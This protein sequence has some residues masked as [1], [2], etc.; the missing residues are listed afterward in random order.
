MQFC[1]SSGSLRGSVLHLNLMKWFMFLTSLGSSDRVFF[2]VQ[3]PCVNTTE[4]IHIHPHSHRRSLKI[5]NAWQ[6]ERNLI[7]FHIFWEKKTC[8]MGNV[9]CSFKAGIHIKGGAHCKTNM[10]P[11]WLM[12]SYEGVTSHIL[13]VT[14]PSDSCVKDQSIINRFFCYKTSLVLINCSFL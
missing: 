2:L 5:Q 8:I 1:S 10:G 7:Y 6:L 11:H 12:C 14:V 3:H 9:L 13:H 4:C